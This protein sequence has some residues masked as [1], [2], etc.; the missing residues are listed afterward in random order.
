M[1]AARV[2]CSGDRRCGTT[3]SPSHRFAM[4]PSSPRGGEEI[5]GSSARTLLS[6][7][8]CRRADLIGGARQ[9]VRIDLDAPAGLAR[10][11]DLAVADPVG[12][13]AE[14]PLLPGVVV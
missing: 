6:L 12:G 9:P 3:P 11:R 14:E 8:L 2:N 5:C 4:G 7:L 13:V 1:M 10:D